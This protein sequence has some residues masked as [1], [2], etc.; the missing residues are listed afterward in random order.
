[1]ARKIYQNINKG[2]FWTCLI[3]SI[4]LIF[5]SFIVPPMAVIDASVI[6]AVGELFAFATLGCVVTAMNKGADVSITKG[7]TTLKVDNP[8]EKTN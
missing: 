4:V 3:L 6:A 8:E 7:D 2:A 5:T 1:M